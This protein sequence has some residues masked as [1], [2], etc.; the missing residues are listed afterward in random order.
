MLHDKG[1]AEKLKKVSVVRA[2]DYGY[3]WGIRGDG[4]IQAL[5]CDEE[6]ETS[7]PSDVD[8]RGALHRKFR[9]SPPMNK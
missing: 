2:A 4:V 8:V 6:F 7:L 1:L 3:S 5:I 9:Y